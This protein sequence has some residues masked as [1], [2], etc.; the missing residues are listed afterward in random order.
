MELVL[1]TALVLHVCLV[2]QVLI[3]LVGNAMKV[4]VQ[5]RAEDWFGGG[6][7]YCRTHTQ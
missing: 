7:C 6:A 3:N 2:S 1:T 5:L 4:N